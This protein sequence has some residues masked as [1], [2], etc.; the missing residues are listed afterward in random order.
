MKRT[1]NKPCKSAYIDC[2]W[3]DHTIQH[4]AAELEYFLK[5]IL[6]FK[7]NIDISSG[8]VTVDFIFD[9]KI[10]SSINETDFHAK[11]KLCGNY[12]HV[13]LSSSTSTG[14]LHAAYTL[15]EEVGIVFDIMGPIIPENLDINRI[16]TMNKEV[17]S[18]LTHRGIRQ[19]INFPM[20]ISSYSQEQA[21]EY[22]KNLARMR[23]NHITFHSYPGQW[24]EVRLQDKTVIA[25]GFFYDRTHIIPESSVVRD[26]IRSNRKYFCIPEIEPYFENAEERSR[27][28][29][30]WLAGLMSFSKELGMWVQLSIEL[31]DEKFD[32]C[33]EICEKVIESYP[34]IDCLELITQECGGWLTGPEVKAEEIK[35]LIVRLFGPETLKNET[36]SSGIN[37]GMWQLPD[38]IRELANH[39]RVVKELVKGANRVDGPE[40]ALGIYATDHDSLKILLELIRLHAPPD[41][42]LAFLTAH[43][44]AA[45]I[46]SIRSMNFTMEELK[47]TMIYSWIEFDGSMFLLQNSISGIEAL[48]KYYMEHPG[49]EAFYGVALNHWRTAENRTAMR[50]FS[51]AS[52][53]ETDCQKEFYYDYAKALR[54]IPYDSYFNAMREIDL[55]DNLVRN[56]LGNIGFCHEPCWL[57]KNR[58]GI[59]LISSFLKDDIEAARKGYKKALTYLNE[60]SARNGY[61][62]GIKYLDLMKNRLKC[63]LKLLDS[64]YA[65][66]D[67]QPI[68]NDKDGSDI[69]Q[70]D[71]LKVDAIC[72]QAM[73]H[74]K[75]YINTHAEMI[76]DRGCEGTLI[77][78]YYT[79]PVYILKLK[80]KFGTSDP[81]IVYEAKAGTDDGPPPPALSMK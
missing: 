68:C 6:N 38:T 23:F 5:G 24:Y 48:M 7:K 20:D 41:I 51:L 63:S 37:D 45:V 78:F 1:N 79:L 73:I 4:A 32:N 2:N 49:S 8:T 60:C 15:L 39:I 29:I 44:A 77:S 14:I 57:R 72:D 58:K 9:F 46:D 53:Q 81:R 21:K 76:A 11:C 27:K 50:Y 69:S 30:E 17:K 54:I 59:G 26:V 65:L 80:V 70:V 62:H 33:V 52:L 25:G 13:I 22:I 36:I 71:R 28:S 34:M 75:E 42:K 31:R 12:Y 35:E 16:I 43:G 18:F 61:E 19:H 66:I 55:T 40:F 10:D 56:T 67:L 64:I 74:A 3:N 47:R